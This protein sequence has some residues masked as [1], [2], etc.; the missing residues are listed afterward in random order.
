M[1]ALTDNGCPFC[2]YTYEN[3][4]PQKDVDRVLEV[5]IDIDHTPAEILRV[6]RT[7][8]HGADSS[9]IASR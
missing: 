7:L 4:A 1:S 9:V 6:G 5:H 8:R 2:G 3:P